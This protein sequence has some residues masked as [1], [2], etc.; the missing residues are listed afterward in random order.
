[1]IL[2]TGKNTSIVQSLQKLVPDEI[3]NFH[4]DLNTF[5]YDAFKA[6]DFR[7]YKRFVLCA[8]I[9]HP[10]TILEQNSEEIKQNIAVN[11]S[12]VIALIDAILKQNGQARIVVMGSASGVK[13]SHDTVYAAAKAGLHQYV[14]NKQLQPGQQL[15]SIA[16]SIIGDAGMTLRRTDKGNLKLR[17][18]ASP[19]KRFVTSLEIA[20]LVHFLLYIDQGFITNTIINMTG[21]EVRW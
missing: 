19:K 3:E 6:V 7:K 10:K 14:I 21:G 5:S 17:E 8:G 11:M 18:Q 16:P 9:L 12:S 13:G 2:V 1:M 15:V 4:L 20:A